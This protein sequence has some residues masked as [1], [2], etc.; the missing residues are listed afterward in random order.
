MPNFGAQIRNLAGLAAAFT[1]RIRRDIYEA[2]D[3]SIGEV[4]TQNWP[5]A[6][7]PIRP[8]GPDGSLPLAINLQMAMN[9]LYQPR[10]DAEYSAVDLKRLS[11]YPLG[12]MCIDNTKDV[13][14]DIK[15]KIQPKIKA[16]ETKDD[17]LKRTGSDE[18]AAQLTKLFERPN[19]ETN[20][21]W[22]GFTR[23]ITEE[24]LSID[25]AAVLI[26]KTRAGKIVEL[27][28]VPGDTIVR[29][30]T[31]AGRTPIPPA[32]AY[33][34]L[35]SGIPRVN[36][37][38]DQLVYKP[39]NIIW[40]NTVASQLYG[41]SPTEA[42]AA[43]LEVGIQRHQFVDAFYR[44]GNIPN[45]LQIVPPSVTADKIKESQAWLNSELAGQ[46]GKLRQ[47]RLIQGFAED[48]KEQIIFPTQPVLS[49]AYDDLHIRKICYGYG[50]SP[51][52]LMRMLNRA[53]AEENQ[54]SAE[55]EG[56]LPWM[57]WLASMANH[58]IQIVMGLEDYEFTFDDEPTLN[59]VQQASVDG[60][61]VREAIVTREEIR[62]KRGYDPSN[63][64]NASKL[65]VMGPVGFVPLETDGTQPPPG[66]APGAPGG[67]VGVPG[68]PGQQLQARGERQPPQRV[69]EVETPEGQKVLKLV[70]VPQLNRRRTTY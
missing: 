10:Y 61:Y 53:S 67:A 20:G 26:N 46:L 33:A 65:G 2:P 69:E 49:D 15:W 14:G 17:H 38:T 29:Y 8:V 12:R 56:I 50:T 34:Q 18:T 68:F 5:S 55:E 44:T 27:V 28:P 31:D 54:E 63:V 35:W 52:R 62:R 24:M 70:L 59:P 30:V 6:L 4:A 47:M 43:E 48:G 21:D 13:L 40:R 16:G 39:R 64:E 25:A 37:R 51:Q 3:V 32:P 42:L 57:T 22:S 36:L 11:M 66:A 23:L 58:I 7:Q 45:A 19:S 60:T 9:L 1:D 41:C